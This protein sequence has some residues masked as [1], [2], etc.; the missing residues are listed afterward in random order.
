MKEEGRIN[1]PAEGTKRKA[2]FGHL[3]W[4]GTN[5]EKVGTSMKTPAPRK[6]G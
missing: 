4:W 3:G 5:K 2:F 1:Q 6:T